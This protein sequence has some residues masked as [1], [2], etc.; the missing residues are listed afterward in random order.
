MSVR[1]CTHIQIIIGTDID[2]VIY[3]IV[4][5]TDND[6]RYWHSYSCRNYTYKDK[7]TCR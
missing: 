7:C 5:D 6:S 1:N 2:I 4:T 3:M